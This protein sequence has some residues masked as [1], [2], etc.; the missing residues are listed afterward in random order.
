MKALMILIVSCLLFGNTSFANIDTQSHLNEPIDFS[1]YSVPEIISTMNQIQKSIRAS[2]LDTGLAIKDRDQLWS[3]EGHMSGFSSGYISGEGFESRRIGDG[4]V[5]I[6]QSSSLS[7]KDQAHVNDMVESMT[8]YREQNPNAKVGYCFQRI[9]ADLQELQEKIKLE[10]QYLQNL[11]PGFF[12]N[13]RTAIDTVQQK[14]INEDNEINDTL[15]GEYSRIFSWA[16]KTYIILPE[17]NLRFSSLQLDN[18]T[19]WHR[20][21]LHVKFGRN[22]PLSGD[23]VDQSDYERRKWV[24]DYFGLT[25]TPVSPEKHTLRVY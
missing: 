22:I 23:C 24:N 8:A 20:N 25:R 7:E 3:L 6:L 4:E 10:E 14:M 5:F 15:Y 13:M 19:F 17:M 12:N 2:F 16:E 9:F 18:K 11:L 1:S 21:I